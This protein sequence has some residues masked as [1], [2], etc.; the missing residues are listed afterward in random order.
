M[1]PPP[2]NAIFFPN[3]CPNVKRNVFS[4]TWLQS[5]PLMGHR[6]LPRV[7]TMASTKTGFSESNLASACG[8]TI[9]TFLDPA[10]PI[11]MPFCYQILQ[12]P[13]HLPHLLHLDT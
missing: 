2:F 5:R 10:Y 7:S 9:P 1:P 12:K 6:I 8:S 3:S 13:F 4:P 11:R